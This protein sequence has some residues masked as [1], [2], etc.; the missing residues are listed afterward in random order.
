[1]KSNGYINGIIDCINKH[2]DEAAKAI[3]KCGDDAAVLISEYGENAAK[4]IGEYGDEAVDILYDCANDGL[5]ALDNGIDPTTIKNLAEQMDISPESFEARGIINNKAA[6]Q[7]LNSRFTAKAISSIASFT[8]SCESIIRNA[9]F[10]S[11]EEF[12]SLSMNVYDDLVKNGRLADIQAV[13]NAIPDPT[14]ETVMQKVISEETAKKYLNGIRDSITGSVAKFSDVQNL[15]TYT[16]LFNGLRLDYQGTDFVIPGTENAVMYAIRFTSDETED[17]VVKSVRNAVLDN[18]A[19]AYP[20]T[21]TGFISSAEILDLTNVPG[22]P[23]KE[24]ASL[25]PEYFAMAVEGEAVSLNN[26]AEMYK[27]TESGDEILFAIYD[28]AK[29]IFTKIGE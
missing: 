26:G 2:G 20:Y 7:V 14:N 18:A 24:G 8:D 16:E 1:M 11:V 19:W 28:K 22:T 23:I 21:G 9:G 17:Q 25:I 15:K 3:G 6:N 13:R 4:H 10:N 5:K 29:S 27:I 12:K